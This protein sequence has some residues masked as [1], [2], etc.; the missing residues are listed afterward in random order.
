MVSLSSLQFQVSH[1]TNREAFGSFRIL[2]RFRLADVN[3]NMTTSINW[4]L[5]A[6]IYNGKP[7]NARAQ[8]IAA[9]VE[10][11]LKYVSSF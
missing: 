4:L 2:Y 3:I 11:N 6:Q 8:Y 10:N 1:N 7:Y 5:L 9:V